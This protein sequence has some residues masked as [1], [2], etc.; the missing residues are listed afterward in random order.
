MLLSLGCPL[1]LGSL[2]WTCAE[3]HILHGYIKKN[4]VSAGYCSLLN[5]EFGFCVNTQKKLSS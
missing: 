5:P 4:Q 2:L 1:D 3:K